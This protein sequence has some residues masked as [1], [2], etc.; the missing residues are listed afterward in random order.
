MAQQLDLCDINKMAA[1]MGVH[2]GNGKPVTG[3]PTANEPYKGNYPF[4]T[5]LGSKSIAPIQMAGVFGAIAN[6]GILCTPRAIDKVV[7]PD[8]KELPVPKQSCTQVISP[9]VAATAAY[10]LHGVLSA[11]GSAANPRDGVPLIGK[12][13]TNE[14][15]G[16]AMALSSTKTATFV[17]A[18][19]ASGPKFNLARTYW[20]G[21]AMKQ[22][23][24]PISRAM[25]RAANSIYGGG[26]LAQP[27]RNL[28]R[29]VMKELPS[30]IGKSVE[31]ATKIIE[32][33]GFSV[34][35]GTPVD[36]TVAAGLVAEQTP[37][38]GSVPG[39][40]TVTLMPSTGKTPPPPAVKVPNV[41]GAKFAQ[42]RKSLEDAGLSVDGKGCKGG[43]DVTAQNPGPDSEV[44]AGSKIM[45][46]CGGEN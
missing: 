15:F 20:E 13:G 46:V 32:E 40:T 37:G 34:Q 39:G 25:Q 10:A 36:S 16:T 9:E 7:G 27:D 4:E 5:V 18:G 35:V 28:T 23:R 17:Y 42:A 1:R 31:E 8:G 19:W 12:T 33:A 24:F 21:K 45:L 38:A 30:V 3:T 43:D 44:P 2:L 22:I 6:K 11:T 26:P 29:R 41:T 14:T